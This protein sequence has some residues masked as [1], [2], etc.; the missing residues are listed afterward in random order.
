MIASLMQFNP[1]IQL[2]FTLSPVRH[3]KDGAE[4]NS[5]SKAS[6]RLAIDKLCSTNVNCSYF[7]AYEIMMDELRDYRFYAEDM[8]H[9]NRLAQEIIWERFTQ[10]AMSEI[11]QAIGKEV[12]ALNRMKAHRSLHPGSRADQEFKGQLEQKQIEITHKYPQVNLAK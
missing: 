9:P 1:G 7:P 8:L 2:V 4:E 11:D 3:W 12:E 10:A 6:L 5:I